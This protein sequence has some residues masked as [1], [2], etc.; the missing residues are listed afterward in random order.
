[1]SGPRPW[2]LVAARNRVRLA[3]SLDSVAPGVF[4]ARM[5]YGAN[6]LLVLTAAA[7]VAGTFNAC[8]AAGEGDDTGESP[9]SPGGSSGSQN[10]SSSSGSSGSGSGSGGTTE[11][12][13]MIADDAI[14]GAT[15]DAGDASSDAGEAGDDAGE[16]SDD[17]APVT[18]TCAAGQTCVDL[19]PTGWTGYVQL[20]LGAGDA[21]AGA[22]AAPYAVSQTTGIADPLGAPADCSSCNCLAGDAGP[23]Q[24]SVGI[25]TAN[26]LCTANGPT[27]PAGQ[28]TCTGVSGGNGS[29]TGPTVTSS[30]GTC[31]PA[32]ALA[33]PSAPPAV[34]CTPGGDAGAPG[35]DAT[36]GSTCDSTQACATPFVARAGSPSGVCIF[37]AGLQTCPPGSY[38]ELHIVGSSV[39]DS[40]GCSC[41][42]VDPTCPT[43][44]YITGYTSSNCSGNPAI[45]FD[46]GTPCKSF[47]N[48]NGSTAFIYHPSHNPFSG[49]CTTVDAGPSGG[50]AVDS[51]SA[52]TYCC[53]P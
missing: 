20:L 27:S 29:A 26:L 7:A 14:P 42:C 52:T 22:C 34:V 32:S 12:A 35:A 30:T 23:I 48:V 8:A 3:V 49:A 46:A 44:G 4:A 2:P 47:G 31:A 36:A 18:T 33:P 15:D 10:S 1:L 9:V 41:G 24:C 40:R 50:V 6:W 21:G 51:A 28:D 53:I 19:A 11:D 38:S 25:A 45:T 16:A 5:Q 39:A 17:A 43:D 13:T 37:Q